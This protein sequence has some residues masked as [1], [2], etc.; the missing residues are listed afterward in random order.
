MTDD[1]EEWDDL[2]L[3][4]PCCA[5]TANGPIDWWVRYQADA[6]LTRPEPQPPHASQGRPGKGSPARGSADGKG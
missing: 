2:S 5:E 6:H 4:E 1:P 3:P